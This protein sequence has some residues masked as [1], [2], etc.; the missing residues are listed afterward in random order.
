MQFALSCVKFDKFKGFAVIVISDFT[1]LK[2]DPR[3]GGI[4]ARDF[5]AGEL[6]WLFPFGKSG[7][8]GY[9]KYFTGYGES[10]IDYNRRTDKVGIGFAILK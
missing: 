3:S 4:S 6:G 2:N 7:V 1:E 5:G 8:Y 9:V 10:L